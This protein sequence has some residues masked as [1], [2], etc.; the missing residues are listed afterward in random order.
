MFCEICCWNDAFFLFNDSEYSPDPNTY[1]N[2]GYNLI[3][4][5]NC[6]NSIY[7][8]HNCLIHNV[9]CCNTNIYD[10]VVQEL[11]YEFASRIIGK[12]WL[13]KIYNID[14]SIGKKFIFKKVKTLN[15]FLINLR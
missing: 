8:C 4:N 6:Y 7:V 12:K 13:G 15:Y 10:S 2:N 3:I 14:D 11:K 1:I 9:Y 5:P